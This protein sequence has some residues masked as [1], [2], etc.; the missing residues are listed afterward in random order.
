MADSTKDKIKYGLLK[1]IDLS[2]FKVFAPPVRLAFGEDAKKQLSDI[3]KFMILP[4]IFVSL[5]IF[6]WSVVAPTHKT[7]SGTVP[8]PS[9]VWDSYEKNSR[10]S[11]REDEKMEDYELTGQ[12]RLNRIKEVK[13]LLAEFE[14]KSTELEIVSTKV[15]EEGADEIQH[16]KKRFAILTTSNKE[17]KKRFYSPKTRKPSPLPRTPK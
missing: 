9:M 15:S 13:G 2:G 7:K 1:F 17:V 4:I 10:F 11:E 14:L 12:E 8:T 5:S 6:I 3:G 16:F